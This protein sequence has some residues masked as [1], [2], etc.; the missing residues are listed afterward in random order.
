MFER[1]HYEAVAEVLR[2]ARQRPNSSAAEC[3]DDLVEDFIALFS[4]DNSAFRAGT[5]RDAT[6][7]K[8]GRPPAKLKRD[9]AKRRQQTAELAKGGA[10]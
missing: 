9:H 7:P 5:F 10:Q 2:L 6:E 8:R 4:R 1:R 3:L